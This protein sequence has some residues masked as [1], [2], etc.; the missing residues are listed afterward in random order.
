MRKLG[1]QC[2][3]QVIN[4]KKFIKNIEKAIF[5]LSKNDESAYKTLLYEIAS[6][7]IKDPSIKVIAKILKKKEYRFNDPVFDEVKK[8]LKEEDDFI[9]TP[10][11]VSEGVLTCKCGSNKTMSYPMQ[12]RS[13]DE[14]TSIFVCCVKCGKKWVE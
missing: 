14:K 5:I 8:I 1:I 12:T 13:G 7:I 4:N 6:K 9:E 3:S 10:F 11:E 2:L